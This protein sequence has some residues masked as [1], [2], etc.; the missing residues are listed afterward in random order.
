MNTKIKGV[1]LAA[2]TGMVFA[3]LSAGP[4]TAAAKSDAVTNIT[5][6]N[7]RVSSS[8]SFTEPANPTTNNTHT[9]VYQL[10]K[11]SAGNA[12]PTVAITAVPDAI[13]HIATFSID[14]VCKTQ[15][16]TVTP[17]VCTEFQS[18]YA[19]GG[20][21][22]IQIGTV[23]LDGSIVWTNASSP[24]TVRA[25]GV[26]AALTIDGTF[27]SQE[28]DITSVSYPAED[29]VQS[30]GANTFTYEYSTDGGTTWAASSWDGTSVALPILITTASDGATPIAN[31]TE[32]AVHL[33]ARNSNG[34]GAASNA[35]L[36]TPRSRP[37]APSG[38]VLATGSVS[39]TVVIHIGT[40]SVVGAGEDPA[41][42]TIT[43]Y[44]YAAAPSCSSW[45]AT[46]V[47]V[48]NDITITGLGGGVSVSF[49][50]RA[51][52]SNG[53][54]SQPSSATGSV[55]T[56]TACSSVRAPVLTYTATSLGLTRAGRNVLRRFAT[57]VSGSDCTSVEVKAVGRFVP[58]RVLLNR[59]ARRTAIA[60][61][62]IV[63]DFL[64]ANGVAPEKLQV[65]YILTS[66]P[67]NAN[68]VLFIL[69]NPP[70]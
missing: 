2:T 67:R 59:I 41:V 34:A 9:Y 5:V 21:W 6:T 68:R 45:S 18:L 20:T 26:P 1:A 24:E 52:D 53:S 31:G 23:L 17:K 61:Y 58:G 3:L 60:R 30:T 16:T 15:D 55:T 66:R 12:L 33:R 69:G 51:V 27:E 7:D 62:T 11:T 47:A 40:P 4:A 38:L 65:S 22:R 14:Q 36:I 43:G 25:T 29:A 37:T 28:I 49:C 39:G 35:L 56:L 63:R 42:V 13:T 10:Y 48:D 70:A 32:Y 54:I 19:D 44:Q 8:V 50:L 64:V 46:Q 57:A